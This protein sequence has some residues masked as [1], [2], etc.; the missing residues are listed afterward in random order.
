MLSDNLRE[1]D[2]FNPSEEHKML[3]QTVRN[4]VEAEVEPQAHE[5]DRA[6]RFNLPLFRKL[7]ELG[8]LG[9]TVPEAYG[10]S[11]MDALAAV[12]VHEE[13]AASDPG[14]ALAYLAHSMLCVNN[15]AVNANDE[16]KKRIL[17]KLCSG[18]WVGCMAMSE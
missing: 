13:I 14:F 9:L 17:P 18:E 1:L 12:I 15:I 11:G 4:F 10:G 16:Q 3:R 8:L 6:E 2:L 5:F 7:G